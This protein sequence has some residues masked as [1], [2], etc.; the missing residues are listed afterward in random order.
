MRRWTTP[1]IVAGVVALGVLAA[2]DAFHGSNKERA[3]PPTASTIH[4]RGRPTVGGTLRRDGISGRLIYSGPLCEIKTVLLPSLKVEPVLSERTGGQLNACS[5]SMA[6]GHFLEGNVATTPDEATI[7]RCTGNSV[8]IRNVETRAVLGRGR[9][10]P[11][12]WRRFPDGR[13][14]LTQVRSGQIVADGRVLVS[15]AQ[16]TAGARKHPNLVGLSRAIHLRIAVS[17]FAWLNEHRVVAILD[18]SAPAIQRERMIMLL[19]DGRLRGMN[20]AFGGLIQHLV[21]SDDGAYAAA[22]PGMIMTLDGRSWDLPRNLG[23]VHVFAFSH[24]DR[25]LAVGTRA[26]VF[27][28]SVTDIRTN[29]PTPR[30]VRIPILATDLVW[31]AGRITGGTRTAG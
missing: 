14:Q 9:G 6:A 5:F 18:V 29:D 28:L 31:E 26:S 30:I 19:D 13:S 1:L 10:C 17:E 20:V 7:A 3:A 2:A 23:L 25:W 21:V 15:H 22:E 12:A 27:L 8:V 4:P 11:A 24:D 16:L